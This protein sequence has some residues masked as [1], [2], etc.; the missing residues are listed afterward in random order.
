[1]NTK[2]KTSLAVLL[3]LPAVCLGGKLDEIASGGSHRDERLQESFLQFPFFT[4]APATNAP[5]QLDFHVLTLNQPL[6]IE[7]VNLYGFRFKVPKRAA[8]ESLVWAFGAP[9]VRHFWYILPETG[10]MPGFED[11]FRQPRAAYEGL[12]PLFPTPPGGKELVIQYLSGDLLEDD[13][14]YLIWFAFGPQKPKR[15]SVAFVFADLRSKNIHNRGVLEQALGLQRKPKG[16]KDNAIAAVARDYVAK[17]MKWSPNAYEIVV[18]PRTDPD[19][20]RIVEIRHQDDA[21]AT[22][23]GGGK[24]L[25]LHIE[26]MRGV[27]VRESAYK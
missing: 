27:V 20:C 14:S 1:M 15:I 24:S 7:G 21:E 6:V 11:F 5:A 13:K 3:L 23:P 4:P 18:T 10:S 17:E 12:P 25:E 2:L 22:H 16:G 19:G 26:A 8:R 9:S